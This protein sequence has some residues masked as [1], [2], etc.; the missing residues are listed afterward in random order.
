MLFRSQ[1]YDLAARI[2]DSSFIIET[3]VERFA[4]KFFIGIHKTEDR[5]ILE[6]LVRESLYRFE[7]EKD[8]NIKEE[9][10]LL[11]KSFQ[12]FYAFVSQVV[13]LKDVWLE[14]LFIYTSWLSRLLPSRDIPSDIFISDD[15][16]SLSAFRLQQEQDGSAS[17]EKGEIATISPI[18]AFGANQYSEDEEISL[19]EIINSFN[20]RYATNFSRED[21]LRFEKVNQEIL[22]EEMKEMIKN[23]PEDVVYGTFANAFFKGLIK[24]FQLNNEIENIVMTDPEAREQATRHF[25]KRAQGIVRKENFA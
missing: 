8:E 10:R 6:N 4:E 5:I 18:N 9:F 15:M 20:Q 14:K 22:N 24:V 17:P 2:N 25:F 19:S 11:L 13:E 12:R 3:D 16:L 21:F 23:N 7:E 1:I